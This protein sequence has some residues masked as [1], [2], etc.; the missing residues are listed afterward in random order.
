[1]PP[2]LFGGVVTLPRPIIVTY[3]MRAHLVLGINAAM[4][5]TISAVFTAQ[6]PV[7]TML[8]IAIM[9]IVLMDEMK[10]M[11]LKLF[12]LTACL[13]IGGAC[14]H[15]NQDYN[16]LY[17]SLNDFGIGSNLNSTELGS[18]PRLDVS[19][20]QL[21]D[22]ASDGSSIRIPLGGYVLSEPIYIN[23]NITLTGS[24]FAYI[25][26]QG[27]SQILQIDNPKASVTIKNFLLMHGSGDYGGA[28][29]SQAKS[30][31]I[32][33]CRFLD[34]SAKYGAAIY[35]KGGNLQV[36]DS[37][38]EGNN[39]TIWGAAIYNEGGDMRVESSKLTQNPGSHVICFNGT[40]QKRVNV[41]IKDCNFSDNPGPYVI[42]GS[43]T[44][45]VIACTDSTVIIDH[46]TI[47]GNKALVVTPHVIGG[48]NAGLVFVGSNIM[49]NDT[50]IEGNV[51]LDVAA[52]YVGRDSKVEVNRCNIAGNHAQSVL[53]NGEYVGGDAAGISIDKSSEV[54]MNDVVLKDNHADGEIGAI[55]SA[56]KLNLKADTV[57]T[58]NSAKR[59][60]ALKG[61]KSGVTNIGKYADIHDNTDMQ[62]PYQPIHSEGILNMDFG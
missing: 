49:L 26:D 2:N 7:R 37:T 38:F 36:M 20:Q 16:S 45:G 18:L 29:N 15:D 32:R 24:P 21:I 14:A 1:M 56:G 40:Q 12:S 61:L 48:G 57:I 34:S 50:L 53:F 6:I 5:L 28:I 51:A 44:G 13:L 10:D 60:S 9:C 3:V 42:R 46:C 17:A 59:Y 23:K 33:D 47:K 62:Q 54:T 41:S 39:A 11:D 8:I 52:I 4:E 25:E 55:E 35:Q 58:R 27:T 30:L 31:T 22:D 43:S 19:L